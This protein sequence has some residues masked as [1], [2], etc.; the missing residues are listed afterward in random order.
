MATNVARAPLV[1]RHNSLLGLPPSKPSAGGIKRPR[2]PDLFNEGAFNAVSAAKRIRSQSLASGAASI[3]PALRDERRERRHEKL[4]KEEEF[5]EKY[6]KAFPKFNFY[7]DGNDSNNHV[8]RKSLQAKVVYLK[9]V[10]FHFS[11]GG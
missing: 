7:F 10:S 5:K 11:A 9:G 6:T 2:S 3:G 1:S 4:L 8:S